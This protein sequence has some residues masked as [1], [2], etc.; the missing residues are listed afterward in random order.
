[1]FYLVCKTMMNLLLIGKKL[2]GKK[3]LTLICTLGYATVPVYFQRLNA[4]LWAK[5]FYLVALPF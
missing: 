3:L 5:N 4:Y 2:G 1:M